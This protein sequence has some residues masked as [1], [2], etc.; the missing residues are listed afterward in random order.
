MATTISDRVGAYVRAHATLR[1]L[2]LLDPPTVR[3]LVP[4]RISIQLRTPGGPACHILVRDGS[5]RFSGHPRLFPSGTLWFPSPVH[6]TRVLTGQKGSAI[7][8][9]TSPRFVSALTGFR[10]LTGALQEQFASAA[11]R[12][13]FLLGGTL[14]ALQEVAGRDPYVTS[15]VRRI[16][17]GTIAITTADLSADGLEVEGW[18]TRQGSAITT[19]IGPLPAEA[20]GSK[21]RP[22]AVLEFKD[23]DAAVA[24]LSGTIPAMLALA[25]RSV[26]LYGRLPMIQNLFPILDRVAHYMGG[27]K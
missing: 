4:G 11:A 5:I 24:L 14:F 13:R 22:N 1:L 18:F 27:G 6:M 10:K 21:A 25:E 26:R 7:P 2:E 12:P 17:D 20:D 15:R 9:P 16:P 23:R 19:G 8:V 3:S